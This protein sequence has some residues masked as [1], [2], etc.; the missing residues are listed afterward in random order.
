MPR[1]HRHIQP[2]Y[3]YHVTHRCHDGAFLLRF[4]R[5]RDDYR[6]WLIEGLGRS[7]VRLLTYCITSN[8]VHLLL[9]SRSVEELAAFMHRAAG[10][11]AQAYNRRK[12]RAGAF[13]S[14]RYHAVMVEDGIH[15]GRC[16]RYIDMNMVRARAVA[17][18]SEWE[19]TGWREL[20]G[21]RRRNRLLS[22]NTLL[23]ALD[24][25]SVDSLRR[26]HANAVAEA[27]G[28]NGVGRE[29]C[30]TES[31]AV[32]SAGFVAD[33]EHTLKSDYTRRKLKTDETR[34]GMWVLRESAPRS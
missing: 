12:G 16:M 2:G 3:T 27:I 32:G 8:H 1:A 24:V 20:M 23:T 22:M 19:W 26:Q 7:D 34:E 30:W 6:R 25:Q 28:R 29:P 4:A 33:I 17:H 11:M 15:L 10:G 9:K 13:W 5:D 21:E 18:P 31:V 14:D